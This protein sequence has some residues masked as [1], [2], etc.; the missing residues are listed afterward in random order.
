MAAELTLCA[1]L[2]SAAPSSANSVNATMRIRDFRFCCFN[3]RNP[4][5]TVHDC[6][7]IGPQEFQSLALRSQ[8]TPRTPIAPPA[9]ANFEVRRSVYA[10]Y[11]ELR[12][13]PEG[14]PL[15][16]LTINDATSDSY[17]V[18]GCSSRLR[19]ASHDPLVG[20]ITGKAKAPH[21]CGALCLVLLL[22]SALPIEGGNFC[23]DYST[24]VLARAMPLA[25]RRP[26]DPEPPWCTD[27]PCRERC[28]TSPA[29]D[30]SV[31]GD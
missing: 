29:R 18:R 3:I 27:P 5:Q 23:A 15:L 14:P 12:G 10:V 1:S 9:S 31:H 16:R 20:K 11:P 6:M 21:C 26:T 30:R 28:G 22:F 17:L 13:G 8:G 25:L 24:V 7:R 4:S 2:T 19:R